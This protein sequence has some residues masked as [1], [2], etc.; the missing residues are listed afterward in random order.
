MCRCRPDGGIMKVNRKMASLLGYRSMA[1][2]ER[3]DFSAA[4]FE[5]GAELPWIVERRLTA[6]S[7]EA[8]ETTWRRKDRRR[9]L[10]RLQ[11]VARTAD[12][13]DLAAEDITGV[14]SLEERLRTAQRMEAVARY[15]SEV[16]A[17]CE[18]LLRNVSQEGQEWVASLASDGSR[19]HGELFLEEVT[20]AAGLLGQLS[21]YG[22]QQQQTA[23][24]VDVTTV[25]KDL[26]PVLKR[27][28]GDEIDLVLPRTSSPIHVDLEAHRLER[29]LVNVAAY[30]RGRMRS[31]G[32]LMIEVA[33]VTLDQQFTEKYPNVRPGPHVLLT[34]TEVRR[35]APPDLRT[36]FDSQPATGNGETGT[37]GVDLGTLQELVNDCG[38]HLWMTAEPPG[39]M[40]LKI[41]LPRRALDELDPPAGVRQSSRPR[42]IERL[43]GVRH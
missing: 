39:D 17:T 33:G 41:H 14:R 2:L 26:G 38:G 13:I 40:V 11:V 15:A 36:A 9:I 5:S 32:R 10:V 22:Q 18:R 4:V 8:V 42:W 29:I 35:S 12:G 16:A 30:G 7:T 37:P 24:L 3:V 31:S 1:D 25:L 20:R 34:V 6:G 21:V 27:V 23:A 19:Y 43:A 28:A